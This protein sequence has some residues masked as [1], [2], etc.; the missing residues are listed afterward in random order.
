MGR[1]IFTAAPPSTIYK[2]YFIMNILLLLAVAGVA[3]CSPILKN[4]PANAQVTY[5]YDGHRLES[6]EINYDDDHIVYAAPAPAVPAPAAPAPAAPAVTTYSAP[7]TQG[8]IPTYYEIDD[9]GD[10][11]VATH[12]VYR[13]PGAAPVL[14]SLLTAPAPAPVVYSLP[15]APAPVVYSAPSVY[16]TYDFDDDDD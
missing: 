13:A 4:L 2:H 15:A 16:Y 6:I 3:Q 12:V 7:A 1:S 9:D 11:D 10:I 14:Y 8:S 5:E